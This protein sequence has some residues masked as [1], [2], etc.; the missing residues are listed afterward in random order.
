M[1]C[2]LVYAGI[3]VNAAEQSRRIVR[4]FGRAHEEKTTWIEGVV[5]RAASLFLELT[6]Q[7]DEH[8]S[9]GNEIDPG[10][11]RVLEQVV[12]GEQQDFPQFLP[13]AITVPLARKE[14]PQ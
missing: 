11:R 4:G 14:S 10:E 2:R 9:T 8:V 1:A 7:I 5:K 13:D 6:I 3:S 12:T